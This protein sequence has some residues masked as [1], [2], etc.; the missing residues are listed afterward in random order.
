MIVITKALLIQ[1]LS[2]IRG[3]SKICAK[4]KYTAKVIELGLQFLIYFFVAV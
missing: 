2:R 1:N 4:N 3:K